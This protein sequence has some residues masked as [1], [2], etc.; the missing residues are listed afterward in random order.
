MAMTVTNII[1]PGWTSLT[2]GLFLLSG[3]IKNPFWLFCSWLSH[4]KLFLPLRSHEALFGFFASGLSFQASSNLGLLS[5]DIWHLAGKKICDI[6]FNLIKF[7]SENIKVCLY[8]FFLFKEIDHRPTIRFSSTYSSS[9]I[10]V[11]RPE[12]KEGLLLLLLDAH[13]SPSSPQVAQAAGG[14][15][16]PAEK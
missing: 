7:I 11:A 12:L 10:L 9:P 1:S 8:F 13:C 15:G 6:N 4:P 16:A 14:H 5:V 2:L 3:D